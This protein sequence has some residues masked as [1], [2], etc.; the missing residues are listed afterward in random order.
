M[1]IQCNKMR[2]IVKVLCKETV[3]VIRIFTDIIPNH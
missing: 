1:S 2:T 3:R